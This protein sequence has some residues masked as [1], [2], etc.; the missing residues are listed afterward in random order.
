LLENEA[1]AEAVV[2]LDQ[3][4]GPAIGIGL[5][6]RDKNFLNSFNVIWVVQMGLEKY[7][8]SLP[9][10]ITGL[11]RV[12]PCLMRGAF[13]DRHGRWARDAV[14]ADALLTNSA[15]ADGEVVWS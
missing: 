2:D 1:D 4:D 7:F 10:Q 5:C 14:D 8:T 3:R 13:R 15:E 12:I 6:L 9:P 11:F